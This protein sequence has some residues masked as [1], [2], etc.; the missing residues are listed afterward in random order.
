V[1]SATLFF[2]QALQELVI[3][4]GLAVRNLLL[5]CKKRNIINSK[6]LLDI[7]PVLEYSL[8]VRS[9]GQQ[10]V[11]FFQY[12]ASNSNESKDLPPKFP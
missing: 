8:I 5:S 10:Q 12:F 2:C 6:F 3:P 4:N 9:N 11:F 1:A 7:E